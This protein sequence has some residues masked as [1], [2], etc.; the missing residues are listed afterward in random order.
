MLKDE[1]RIFQNLYNDFGA[2][3]ESAKKRGDW[4]ETK[5]IFNKGR[6]WI[7]E[8]IKTSQLRGRGGAGFPTGLKWS[9]A[10]KEVGSKPHYLVINADESE[11]G[12]CKDRDILRFEPHKLIEG[13][14]IASYA[15]NAHTCYIY[16][17]GEYF[18][19]GQKLQKAID[20]AYSK[21]LI[22]KNASSTGWDFDIFLSLIHI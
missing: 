19:E 3:L 7:I 14:L 11:P 1:D 18:N 22:G 8:E 9:F 2:E 5:E 17:R 12:T 13:C 21:G 16:I 15:V 10:P 4:L 20:E 6:G